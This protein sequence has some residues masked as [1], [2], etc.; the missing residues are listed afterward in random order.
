MIIRITYK[1]SHENNYKKNC[2]N[3]YNNNIRKSSEIIKT[4]ILKN[5]ITRH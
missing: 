3:N 5:V 1:N 2:K 4:A